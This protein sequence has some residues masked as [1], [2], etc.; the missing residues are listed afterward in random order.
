MLP[1]KSSQLTEEEFSNQSYVGHTS[2]SSEKNVCSLSPA[3]FAQRLVLMGQRCCK[4]KSMN[5]EMVG[6]DDL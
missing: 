4:K 6:L 5:R 2:L 3:R 1:G